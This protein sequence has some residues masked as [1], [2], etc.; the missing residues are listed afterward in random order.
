MLLAVDSPDTISAVLEHALRSRGA[1]ARKR[2]LEKF[3]F[4]T[5][6][7]LDDMEVCAVFSALSKA[8]LRFAHDLLH[9]ALSFPNS[10][11]VK[12]VQS[13]DTVPGYLYVV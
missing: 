3:R 12:S 5:S 8:L 11:Q 13:A 7:P 2:A 1:A 4:T 10:T 9:V 6:P